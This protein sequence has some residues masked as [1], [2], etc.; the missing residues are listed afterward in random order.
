MTITRLKKI[1]DSS[2]SY[3]IYKNGKL[4]DNLSNG[5]SIAIKTNLG[6]S[7]KFKFD[8]LSSREIVINSEIKEI[9]VCSSI[10]NKYSYLLIA[11]TIILLLTSYFT[12]HWW[13]GLFIFLN[14]IFYKTFFDFKNYIKVETK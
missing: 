2:R 3:K 9:I 5:K 8:W 6:D 10:S 12:G 1:Q 7:L 13:I 14:K 4:V 11:S